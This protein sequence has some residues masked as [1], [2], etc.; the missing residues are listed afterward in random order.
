MTDAKN[1]K[2]N[3]NENPPNK[4]LVKGPGHSEKNVKHNP[5]HVTQK[6]TNKA[7]QKSS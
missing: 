1:I 5:D 7:E 4:D 2:T 3:I 6:D